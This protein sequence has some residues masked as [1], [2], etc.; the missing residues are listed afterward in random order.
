MKLAREGRP[1]R[2]D[3]E[4]DGSQITRE[5]TRCCTRTGLE[6]V[7]PPRRRSRPRS[8]T[9]LIGLK[10]AQSRETMPAKEMEFILDEVYDLPNKMQRF[11]DGDHPIEEIAQQFYEKQSSSTWP[12][13]RAAGGRR[14][15]KLKEIVHPDRRVLGRR[16]NTGRSP[17]SKRNARRGRRDADSRAA[18]NR[19]EHQRPVP[20]AHVIAIAT[21]GNETS[22]TTP[23]T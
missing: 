23:T 17:C 15:L 10:L 1:H 12:P 6:V 22:S 14:A 11:L 13:Y 18:T 2:R 8:L 16:M 7:W 5:M 20:A 21:D 9:F 3:H 4:H 19:L